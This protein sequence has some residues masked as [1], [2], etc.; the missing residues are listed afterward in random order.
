MPLYKSNSLQKPEKALR[1]SFKSLKEE[2]I[3]SKYMGIVSA[4]DSLMEYHQLLLY[5]P[6]HAV[7]TKLFH[8][9]A[10]QHR[11]TQT[12]LLLHWLSGRQSFGLG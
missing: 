1:Q 8:T 12:C 5:K 3:M 2:A 6:T 11:R 7:K 4:K 9:F 10:L